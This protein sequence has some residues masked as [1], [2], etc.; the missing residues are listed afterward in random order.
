MA[1]G[2]RPSRSGHFPGVPAEGSDGTV[3]QGPHER[4]Q[5]VVACH[6]RG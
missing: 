2:S 5:S 6:C 1:L 4:I 3:L